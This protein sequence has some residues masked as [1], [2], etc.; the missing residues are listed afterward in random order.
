[1]KRLGDLPLVHQP[2]EKWMYHTGSDV[3][4]V[5]MARATGR[6]LEEFLTERLFE[7][8]GMKDT[9]FHVPADKLD[10]LTASY[11]PDPETGAL[12]LDDDPRQSPVG[13][14]AHLPV[15]GWR[16]GLDRRR[17]AGLLH[18]DAEQGPAR[19]ATHPVAG[20]RSS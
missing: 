11:R 14:A 7:P 4:G 19:R 18:D 10:R 8:L 16:T 15:R 12:V 13:P 2:G 1:M 5:L 6:P 3:L 9:G 17:P 20:R